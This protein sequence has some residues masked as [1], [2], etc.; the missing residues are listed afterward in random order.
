MAWGSSYYLL[1]VLAAPIAADTGWSL[2]WVVGGLSVGL[3]AAAGVSPVVGRAIADRGGRPVLAVSACLLAAGLL[4]LSLAHGLPVFLTA[5]LVIGLGMGAGLYDPAFA[6]LGRLYG[7]GGRSAITAL[8]LFGGFASTVCWPLSAFLETHLGWRGACLTY[9]GI[10]L[11]V[12]LPLYLFGLPR[13]PRHAVGFVNRAAPKATS[14]PA[15]E[16]GR[17]VFPLLA[18][19]VT[20]ASMIS[21]VFSVHLL[22]V[23]QGKGIALAAAVGLGALVGPSQVGARAIEMLI[24][25]HHHPIL[26]KL[27]S[28]SLVALGLTLLWAGGPLTTLAL[29][30]YGAGI[31][32]ESIARGTLPLVV[33]GPNRYPVLMGRIAMPNLMAQAA[34]PAMG[35]GLLSA[36][37]LDGG[38]AVFTA[39]AACNVVLAF[40]LLL[41]LRP[42]K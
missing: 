33:F 11:A 42:P 39:A 30:F 13:E 19:S 35:T 7:D 16:P 27:A 40:C 5:W 20:L 4:L 23:L 41:T 2:S 10:Q 22:T 9:A 32:L 29:V 17:V 36:L 6:T 31:G 37:G 12:S 25:R 34:A 26:T 8:T 1:A 21:T 38:L 14:V 15:L 28:A 24:A 3:L 18:C